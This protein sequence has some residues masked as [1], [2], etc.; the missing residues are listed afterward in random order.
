MRRNIKASNPT[1]T[2]KMSLITDSTGAVITETDSITTMFSYLSS[3]PLTANSTLRFNTSDN[4]VITTTLTLNNNTAYTLTIRNI[5]GFNPSI[6]GN[7]TLDTLLSTT[8]GK[9][10]FDGV[11]FKKA[12]VQA[13]DIGQTI[14]RINGGANARYITFKNCIFSHGYCGIRGTD[15][16]RDLTVQDCKFYQVSNCSLRI[17]NG[18]NPF[19]DLQDVIIERC[20]FRDDLN[21]AVIPNG[22]GILKYQPLLLVKGCQNIRISNCI[23]KQTQE[24]NI[25]IE[26]SDTVI[27]ENITTTDCGIAAPAA[28]MIQISNSNIVTVRNCYIYPDANFTN[29]SLGITYSSNIRIYYC[30]ILSNPNTASQGGLS[31]FRSKTVLEIAG[32]IINEGIYYPVNNDAAYVGTLATDYVSEHDNVILISDDFAGLID[33]SNLNIAD[34]RVQIQFQTS[35]A[36]YQSTYSRGGNSVSGRSTGL[37]ISGVRDTGDVFLLSPSSVGYKLVPSQ[38]STITTD[39]SGKTRTYPTSP[40]AFH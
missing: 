23:F 7:N 25:A 10:V 30:S 33:I 29:N 24:N 14:V 18:A 19:P 5:K 31:L 13:S 40:G 28:E 27:V 26:T 37:L 32:N 20:F 15:G 39:L 8:N 11:I 17:G 3:N 35:F 9:L 36:T 2:Y 21:E 22:D 38:I 12:L 6:D 16:I 4:Y 34:I 1:Y